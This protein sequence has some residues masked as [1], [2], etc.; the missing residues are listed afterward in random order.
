MGFVAQAQQHPAGKMPLLQ[1]ELASIS[2]RATL[3]QQLRDWKHAGAT[4]AGAL[5][6]AREMV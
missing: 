5:R 1:P 3:Q 4:C 6:E 2:R